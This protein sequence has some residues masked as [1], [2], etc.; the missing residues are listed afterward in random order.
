[1]VGTTT[2]SAPS[3]RRCSTTDVDW[4]L[5]RGHEHAPAEQRPVLEPRHG[6]ALAD[7]LADD[8]ARPARAGRSTTSPTLASATSMRALAT[9]WSRSDTATVGVSGLQP[10]ATMRSA[11][12]PSSARGAEDDDGVRAAAAGGDQV[13][14]PAR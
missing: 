5:V 8:Q 10:S 4:S 11:A 13:G 9:W 1:M 12:P 7:G 14:A 2:G 6:L 3:S